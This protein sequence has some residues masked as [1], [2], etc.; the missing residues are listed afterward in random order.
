MLRPA[1]RILSAAMVV[2]A[3][4]LAGFAPSSRVPP[5]SAQPRPSA[6]NEPAGALAVAAVKSAVV[7][8][9]RFV[10]I[11]AADIDGDGDLDVVASDSSLQLH[12]WV[13][14][15]SGHFT[16]RRPRKSQAWRADP[17]PSVD[18]GS[19]RSESSTRT[20]PPSPRLVG[21]SISDLFTPSS[22]PSRDSGRALR[23]PDR[24]PSG[25]RAPPSRLI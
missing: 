17:S 2:G 10:S 4:A 3:L 24:S 1:I 5:A 21:R 9:S 25:P 7:E 20:D 11:V 12:V 8:P 22:R 19:G 23:A 6:R 13:N 18:V 15:G 14:D 16:M